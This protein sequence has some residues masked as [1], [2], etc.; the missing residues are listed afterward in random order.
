MLVSRE[1]V[2][3][4]FQNLFPIERQLVKIG[5][6]VEGEPLEVAVI[7]ADAGT[8]VMF[9][10]DQDTEDKMFRMVAQ[11]IVGE[12]N[13]PVFTIDQLKRLPYATFEK[14]TEAA[15]SVN[16]LIKGDEAVEDAEKNLENVG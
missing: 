15:T 1:L 6:T 10:S 8:M 2:A 16:K 12:D 5:E 4:E 13:K 14:L 11:S 7:P 9:I 3:N